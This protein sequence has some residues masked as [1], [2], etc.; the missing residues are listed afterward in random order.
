LTFLLLFAITGGIALFFVCLLGFSFIFRRNVMK[1]NNKKLNMV[2]CVI[3]VIALALILF[4]PSN[5][6]GKLE[7]GDTVKIIKTG[8]EG[9]ITDTGIVFGYFVH[10]YTI[11]PATGEEIRHLD[12]F[13]RSQ[14]EKINK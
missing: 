4:W 5:E 8:I 12:P 10:Y 1:T 9:Q 14:L 7:I 11:D 13:F 6:G 2:I 3:I